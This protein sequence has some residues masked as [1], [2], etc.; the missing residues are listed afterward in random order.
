MPRTTVSKALEGTRDRH[1]VFSLA[2][3]AVLS[4]C[5]GS[6][7]IYLMETP[8]VY[9]ES[10]IDPFAHLDD[11]HH[12]LDLSVFFATNRKRD[13]TTEDLSTYGNEV[14]DKL[15]VG[16]ATVRFG[17]DGYSWEQLAEDSTSR[18][19][20]APVPLTLDAVQQQ[21]TLT[22]RLPDDGSGLSGS[23][24]FGE[25]INA[26]LG[27]AID[28]DIVIY[29]HGTKTD[30]LNA[31]VLA[32]EL[33]HFAGRDFVS[34]AYAWPA[35]QDIW[36]YFGGE[37]VQ[38]ARDSSHG[39]VRLLEFLATHTSARRIHLLSYS[40][41]GRVTSKAL[42]ELKAAHPELSSEALRQRFRL[43]AV[44]FAAADVPVEV[45]VQRLPAASELADQVVVTVSDHDPALIA[46]GWFMPGGARAGILA[47]EQEELSFARAMNLEDFHIVDLSRDEKDR[48]FDITGHKYWY[49]HPWAS[50]DVMLLLRTDLPPTDRALTPAEV[51][52]I[53]FMNEDYPSA[54]RAQTRKLLGGTWCAAT[55]P[56]C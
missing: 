46:A 56:A 9:E 23:T 7:A 3:V 51:R 21:G 47:A 54:V 19:R 8:A 29:V 42:Q 17:D 4:G 34:L 10:A 48:G 55:Q 31:V 2:I 5:S 43:G 16:F 15:H 38:R 24:L 39:L 49:R 52:G 30:F 20:D 27:R 22:L 13:L 32:A 35:H 37:D 1:R 6:N 18:E 53:Y 36:S 26:E 45:F 11:S 41:G 44:V 50:S 14:D 33:E 12:T 28:P 40:A 25:S